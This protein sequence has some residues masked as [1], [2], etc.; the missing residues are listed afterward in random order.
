[1][2][3]TKLKSRLG[4]KIQSLQEPISIPAE[5]QTSLIPANSGYVA[6]NSNALDIIKDNLKN[7]PLSVQLF[8]IVKAP[9]GGATV[10]SVPGLSGD[11]AEKELTGIILDYTTPRAYWES[12]DP[13]EGAP[14]TCT[15]PNSITS[16]D[17]KV[18][19][20][21]PY[22]D[23]GSKGGE[24]SAKACKEFVL[25][26]LLRPEN[27]LPLLVRIPVSSKTRF[28]RYSTRL[29]SSLTPI[30]GVVTR[31]TLEKV[32]NKTGKPYAQYNFE[33]VSVLVAEEAAQVKVFAQQFMEIINAA[34]IASE[35]SEAS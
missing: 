20:H 35:L 33:A 29:L 28:L 12:A 21:C 27:A 3:T 16:Y 10:F 31:I 8:D 19:A 22:N 25:L 26:F 14:P 34:E 15:S 5:M 1:M 13:V 30:N 7:Q 23:F 11:E 24:S 6:L 17:G 2:D 32:T 18:C 9:S 4:T